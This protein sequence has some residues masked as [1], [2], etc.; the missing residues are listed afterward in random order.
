MTKQEVQVAVDPVLLTIRED[1]L[2][3]LL[4]VRRHEPCKGELSFPG[5]FLWSTDNDLDAAAARKLATETGLDTSDI[6]MEQ[7]HAYGARDRDPRGRV[8]AVAYLAIQPSVS[9]HASDTEAGRPNWHPVASLLSGQ[10]PLAFDHRRIL[11]DAVE[12][13][14]RKLEHTTLATAFCP[15]RFTMADLRR[16]YEI[17]WGV[18]GLDPRNFHRKVLSTKGFVVATR[19][20]RQQANGRPATLYRKA[21]AQAV[22]LYPPMLRERY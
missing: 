3:V 1:Q 21:S 7:L 16:V 9:D 11:A 2:Q 6:H 5:G 13:A 10:V 18:G 22:T 20:K 19:A 17:V 8:V 4:I 14:R 12:A 15:P